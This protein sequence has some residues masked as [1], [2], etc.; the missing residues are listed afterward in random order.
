MASRAF[1]VLSAFTFAGR[2]V[3]PHRSNSKLRAVSGEKAAGLWQCRRVAKPCVG[4]EK[5]GGVVGSGKALLGQG[6]V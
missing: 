3:E 1:R 2:D 4:D 6:D 5:S